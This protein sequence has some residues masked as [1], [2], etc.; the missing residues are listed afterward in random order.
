[1]QLLE[2][3][4][5]NPAENLALDEA[6]LNEAEE[7]GG[8]EECLRLW[9]PAQ[10]LVVVGRSSNMEREVNLL[11]CRQDGVPVLRRVSGGL[12]IVTGPGCLMYSLLLSYEKRPALRSLQAAH[13]FVLNT[14]AD[15]LA[16]HCGGIH[17]AGTSDLAWNPAFSA[18]ETCRLTSDQKAGSKKFSG[19]S[20]RCRRRFFLYHG[21]LLYRFPLEK[22]DRYLNK[23]PR[24]PDYRND[25]D[26]NGFVTNLPLDEKEIRNTFI[27]AWAATEP[28]Q[29]MPMERMQKIVAEKYASP[30][31]Y[32][33]V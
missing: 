10:T 26:H 8:T 5:E 16:P 30:E 29:N 33:S 27:H 24:M 9:E 18:A 22:I 20:V 23:P 17:C 4:L 1:M 28:R 14:I 6:L 13:D 12:A 31:W 11:A 25:R 15:G 32:F 21:T 2:R 3:T 7:S 19:N